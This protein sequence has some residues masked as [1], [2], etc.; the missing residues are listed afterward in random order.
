MDYSKIIKEIGRGKNHARDLDQPTAYELYKAMLAGQV[1]ALELGGILIALRIKGESEQEILGFY[2]AMQ[3]QVMSLRTPQGRPLPIVIPSYNGARKQANLTPLLALLLARLGLPV[4]VHGVTEDSSRVT[5]GEIFQHL[6]IPWS[7]SVAEAQSRLDNGLPV[8]IPVS[9]L[10]AQLDAQLQQRWRMGVRNSS[11]T[12]AKLAT[13]FI[14]DKALRLASV[15][16]P[17]YMQKVGRFF[18]A[19]SAPALLQQGTEG[20]VYANPLRCPPIHYIN[21]GEQQILLDRQPEP[22]E[23][24]LPLAKD[25]ATTAAWIE[26]CLAGVLPVPDSIQKQLACCLVA[27]GQADTLEQALHQI[28]TKP[29]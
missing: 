17:E 8:F 13:P 20:E 4:V 19:I 21:E 23:Q 29:L 10:S 27:V 18:Q 25:T 3:E 14:H 1:P 5:S 9:A 15:S 2:Q 6:N 24:T 16:H 28:T 11:H 7:H 12:L 22:T 26:D